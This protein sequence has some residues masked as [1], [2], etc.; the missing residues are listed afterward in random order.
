MKRLLSVILCL[1]LSICALGAMAEEEVPEISWLLSVGNTADENNLVLQEIE[2]RIG[3]KINPIQCATGD[4][5]TKLNS[6]IAARDLPDMFSIGLTDAKEF[7]AEGML[8]PLDEYLEAYGQNILAKTGDILPTAEANQ[9]DGNTYMLV[10]ANAGYVNNYAVRV[11]WLENLGLEMPTDLDSLYDVLY[12]FTYDDPDQNGA[13]DTIGLV[14]TMTQN[15][16]WEPI[17]G[18]FGIAYNANALLED[19]T[20]TTYMKHPNYLKAIEYLRKLYQDGV[21]DPE[22]AT[23]PAM[24]AHEAL[25]TG[26]CGTYGFQFVGTTNNWYPG[27]YTFECPEDPA[28]IFGY[29]RIVGEDGIGGSPKR[30]VNTTSGFVVASTAEHPEAVVKFIDFL[31]TPEGD[32]LTYLGVEGVMWEWDDEANGKYHRL[33]GYED[34]AAHRAAGGFTFWCNVLGEDSIELRTMNALTQ[35]AQAFDAQYAFDWPYL[36]TAL[37]ASSEYGS[38]LDEIVAE[39][40]A[41][42]IVTTG[43]VEA[44]YAAFVERWENEGGLEW[45]EEATQAYAGKQAE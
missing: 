25:W 8:L 43:D 29:T 23:M 26:R 40:L 6:L 28:E 15:N 22:F 33:P 38:T 7:I 35:E 4:F 13:Q 39:A 14:L 10:S 36:D 41:Q 17:F 37:E 24:T 20:V 45:E 16:Q 2:K 5:D 19:G 30:Y 1:A 42:L 31:F 32:E 9:I 18:A 44:E 21:M 11:D 12:A 34:D 3:V 27:R